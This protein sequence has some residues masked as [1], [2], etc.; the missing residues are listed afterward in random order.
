M[1]SDLSGNAEW[2]KQYIRSETGRRTEVYPVRLHSSCVCMPSMRT[3]HSLES[4]SELL[5]DAL[6]GLLFF[7][8]SHRRRIVVEELALFLSHLP[9]DVSSEQ[10]TLSRPAHHNLLF[11]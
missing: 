4:D 8:P 10:R 7:F 3:P 11:C 1:T 2:G 9:F 5:P 6:E